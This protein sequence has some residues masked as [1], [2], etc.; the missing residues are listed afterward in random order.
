MIAPGFMIFWLFIVLALA[1]VGVKLYRWG[2]ADGW[3]KRDREGWA[4]GE[5]TSRVLTELKAIHS[6]SA[7]GGDK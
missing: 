1:A 5:M 2:V 7:A 3:E 6:H 4:R